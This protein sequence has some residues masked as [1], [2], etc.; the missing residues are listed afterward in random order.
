MNVGSNGGEVKKFN[1][2]M[3][4]AVGYEILVF[5]KDSYCAIIV[6]LKCSL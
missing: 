1:W 4:L 5:D 3:Y 6:P 2:Q